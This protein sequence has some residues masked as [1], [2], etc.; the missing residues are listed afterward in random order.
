MRISDVLLSLRGIV[1]YELRVVARYRWEFLLFGMMPYFLAGFFYLVGMGI[2]GEEALRNF[3]SAT[4]YK[5]AFLYMLVGSAVLLV[6]VIS[7]ES[8]ISELYSGLATGWLELLMLTRTNMFVYL[9]GLSTPYFITNVMISIFSFIPAAIYLGGV[10]GGVRLL[11]VLVVL[12]IGLLPLQGISLII[13]TF[14]VRYKEPQALSQ[15]VRAI[16]LVLSGCIYPIYVLPRWMQ[17]AALAFPPYYMSE[18]IRVG[19]ML[20]NPY[21]TLYYLG[22]ILALTLLYYPMGLGF[23]KRFERSAKLTGE[24]SKV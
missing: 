9:F 1:K 17:I 14:V 15:P 21:L 12:F 20:S 2:G 5:E 16:L 4:G 7:I 22:M 8:V 24:L 19:I 10:E 3:M 11:L 18:A 13:A 23:Y 6:I